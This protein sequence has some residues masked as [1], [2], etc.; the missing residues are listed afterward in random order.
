VFAFHSGIYLEV[1][2][3]SIFKGQQCWAAVLEGTIEET[4]YLFKETGTAF[5]TGPLEISSVTRETK[6]EVSHINDDIALHVLKPCEGKRAATLHL[7]SKPIPECQIYCP[8]T[9][10][11]TKRKTGYYTINKQIQ[12]AVSY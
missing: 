3:T 6:G 9:G 1:I 12:P 2:L 7:Y 8:S 10:T 11:I 4:H 5:G